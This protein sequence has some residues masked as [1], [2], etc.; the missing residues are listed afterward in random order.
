M[1]VERDEQRKL[2][3]PPRGHLEE[4]DAVGFETKSYLAFVVSSL[5]EIENLQIAS[6]LAPAV[7]KFL[8]NLEI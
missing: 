8:A 2:G 3:I 6:A 5:D 7:Y 4:Y 1:I